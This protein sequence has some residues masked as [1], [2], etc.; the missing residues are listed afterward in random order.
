MNTISRIGRIYTYKYICMCVNN[1]N[2]IIRYFRMCVLNLTVSEM[3]AD[4][5]IGHR[6]DLPLS[7]FSF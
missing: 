4:G 6:T 3:S 1:N 7:C 2:S 5:E